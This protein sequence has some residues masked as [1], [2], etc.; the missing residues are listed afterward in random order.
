LRCRRDPLPT[1]F[2][3]STQLTTTIPANLIAADG[4]LLISVI[5]PGVSVSNTVSLPIASSS[6]TID[7]ITPTS[8]VA[9]GPAFT[10]TVN[11]NGFIQASKVIGLAGATTTFVS[12]TQLTAS[13]PASA[14]AKAGTFVVQVQNPG[15][16]PSPQAKPFLVTVSGASIS[17]LNPSSAPAGGAAFTLTVAGTGFTANSTVQWNGTALQTTFTSATQL[18][19]QVPAS[20]IATAG[21][22]N[23]TVG[24]DGG[25]SNAMA[26]AIGS[27]LPATSTAGIVNAASSAPALA[28]G[29]L[30]SIYGSNLASGH[31]AAASIPLDTKLGGTAVSINGIAA[32][33]LFVSPG[34]INLQVP[35]EVQPGPAKVVIQSNGLQSAAVNFTVAATGPGVFTVQPTNRGGPEPSGFHAQ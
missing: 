22:A 34:Q 35:Y 28:P 16:T 7:S 30:I 2:I 20:L 14:I 23:V 29:A 15:G 31:L 9:G 1:T 25:T 6:P 19:A 13:V 24:G 4:A 17:G 27:L 11:G 3:S 5:T 10:L 8:A 18:T 26:F 33:L 32:P 21:T 12:F